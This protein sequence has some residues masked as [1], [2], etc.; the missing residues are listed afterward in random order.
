MKKHSTA[1]KK[2]IQADPE[3]QQFFKHYKVLTFP[4]RTEVF[5][6]EKYFVECPCLH[7]NPLF[8]AMVNTTK[9]EQPH[10][11]RAY[12]IECLIRGANDSTIQKHPPPRTLMS[13]RG[14]DLATDLPS[15]S[16]V[17]LGD[18]ALLLGSHTHDTFMRSEL[19]MHEDHP[20]LFYV[21]G[22]G[23]DIYVVGARWREHCKRWFL[24]ARHF[25]DRGLWGMGT[26]I[27]FPI[28]TLQ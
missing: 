2:V 8:G 10:F 22:M 28:L 7:I 15:I 13:P 3:N 25:D 6:P 21:R 14:A 27:A 5:A 26:H 19:I 23:G 9:P 17:S 1:S 20:T 4:A 12:T 18:I 16:I 24:F 11:A